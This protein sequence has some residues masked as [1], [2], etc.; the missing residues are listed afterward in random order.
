MFKST[1]YI[2]FNQNS[3][4]PDSTSIELNAPS[5]DKV[6]SNWAFFES[7]PEERVKANNRFSYK[8]SQKSKELKNIRIQVRAFLKNQMGIELP[9]SYEEFKGGKNSL[10]EGFEEFEE[11]ASSVYK[12][13]SPK[14]IYAVFEDGKEQKS[15]LIGCHYS[16][17]RLDPVW[18]YRKSQ[19]I[20]K[21]WRNYLGEK[22][23]HREYRPCHLVLTVPH[24][25]GEFGGK[26]F[27]GRDLIKCFN[28][29]RKRKVW[30]NNVHGGE[31]GLEVKK[32]RNNGLHIHI[33]SLC[34]IDWETNLNDLRKDLKRAWKRV[35]KVPDEQNIFLHLE[36]LYHYNKDEKE[37]IERVV[38]IEE[39]L[40]EFGEYNYS[41]VSETYERKKKVYITKDS[42]DDTYIKGVMECIKYHFKGDDFYVRDK[43]HNIVK[44][45]GGYPI[46][47]V[48]LFNDV[49][50]HSKG[51]RLYSKF[52]FC[53]Q[54]EMLN[55]DKLVE[56][57][58]TDMEATEVEMG[59]VDSME[60]KLVNPIKCAQSS[61][62]DYKLF[63]ATPSEIKHNPKSDLFNPQEPKIRG[64]Q[65]LFECNSHLSSSEVMRG[66]L[67]SK[68]E[69]V[70]TY[71]AFEQFRHNWGFDT[72][73]DDELAQI[74]QFE[75]M[76]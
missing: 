51:L 15:Q 56:A 70:M 52:G 47:D 18:N 36:T 57:Q 26:Q 4:L 59:S 53:Y 41:E 11:L 72:Q 10:L 30:K 40:N 74:M 6:R 31:Y 37:T 76:C 22:K 35:C 27:Y 19:L 44:N 33:H 50:V 16:R 20:R 34:F 62:N 66:V 1:E 21:V 75:D 48:P 54:E 65:G 9:L 2:P 25:D 46:L 55:Y 24:A 14:G 73:R 7:T 39:N 61:G 67:M 3:S 71:E 12:M 49:L 58:E 32:S 68:Y 13:A 45:G 64:L 38:G 69:T 42:D 29:L 43:D 60:S 28:T 23:V 17:H 63:I 5:L 8:I